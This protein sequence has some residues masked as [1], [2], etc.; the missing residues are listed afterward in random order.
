MVNSLRNKLKE[1]KIPVLCEA[2][3][4]QW[5]NHITQN[6]NGD[7]LTR[8]HGRTT[9][10]NTS[11]LSKDKCIEKLST[12]SIV[13][14]IHRSSISALR[15]GFQNEVIDNLIILQKENG[16]LSIG[17]VTGEM[18]QV[19]SITPISR[20][21][22][23]TGTRSN[24][25]TDLNRRTNVENKRRK[26]TP[27][28]LQVGEKNIL[29]LL[30]SYPDLVLNENTEM[31]RFLLNTFRFHYAQFCKEKIIGNGYKI[32]LFQCTHQYLVRRIHEL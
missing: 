21:D 11:K 5:H 18:S 8:M 2:Y 6:A 13:K 3:D 30:E 1:K 22:L 20:P 17:T 29:H 25:A 15:R 4:G 10:L 26:K 12:Y 14:D 32:I 27:I 23:F 31:D 9:W 19:V 16:S 7:H 24:F 28:G